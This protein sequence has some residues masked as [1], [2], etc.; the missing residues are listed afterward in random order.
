MN[1]VPLYFHPGVRPICEAAR[2]DTVGIGKN[3]LSTCISERRVL[4]LLAVARQFVEARGELDGTVAAET[5]AAFA[6]HERP[7][8]RL[9][10]HHPG[11]LDIP[12]FV[13]DVRQILVAKPLLIAGIGGEHV[14]RSRTKWSEHPIE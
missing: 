2:K 3:C 4:P 9:A 6:C 8:F 14:L 10:G 7:R 12:G 1:G 11:P 13:A 5:H